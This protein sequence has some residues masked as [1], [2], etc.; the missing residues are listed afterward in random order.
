MTKG[1]SWLSFNTQKPSQL[2]WQ[3]S[4]EKKI[5]KSCC[6]AIVCSS[7]A[8]THP[9]VPQAPQSSCSLPPKCTHDACWGPISWADDLLGLILTEQG[10]SPITHPHTHTHTAEHKAVA[11]SSTDNTINILKSLKTSSVCKDHN[12][13]PHL[14]ISRSAELCWCGRSLAVSYECILSS[15]DHWG[16]KEHPLSS[17]IH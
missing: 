14:L 11:H 16:M 7:E 5:S 8:L 3:P 15:D 2:K 9:I 17:W 12:L 1:K 6:W 4:T 13:T 10:S